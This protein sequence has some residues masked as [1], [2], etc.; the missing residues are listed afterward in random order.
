[1][2]GWGLVLRQP[3]DELH[4]PPRARRV[5]HLLPPPELLQ[6]LTRRL[7]LVRSGRMEAADRA[8]PVPVEEEAFHT[9]AA[10]RTSP[11]IVG[12]PEVRAMSLLPPARPQ[13]VLLPR[14]GD[15]TQ[16]AVNS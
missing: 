3:A 5:R 9:G 14:C 11:L 7:D 4:R 13:L 2:V 6:Q 8:I 15:F 1:M 16:P 12:T 10:E